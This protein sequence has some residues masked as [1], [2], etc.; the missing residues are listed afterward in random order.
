ME[1]LLGLEEFR[2]PLVIK[3]SGSA[4]MQRFPSL[5]DA[6]SKIITLYATPLESTFVK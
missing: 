3:S 5:F 4:L 1:I 2:V 6:F